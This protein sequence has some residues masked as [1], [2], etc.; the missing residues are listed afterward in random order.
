MNP[1]EN[2]A[3]SSANARQPVVLLVEDYKANILVAGTILENC[4]YLWESA[5]NGKEAFD[6]FKHNK[7]DIILMDVQMPEMDGISTTKAIRQLETQEN[8]EPITI[9]GV[10]AYA[11][12]KDRDRCLAAG[13]N[14]FISK[15]FNIDN[16][17]EKLH[18]WLN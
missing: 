4:G 1:I 18:H 3:D 8:R 14:D 13:M 17:Q 15:P 5:E 11:E 10:T 2:I 9:I 6:K 7:Y 12:N 16:L